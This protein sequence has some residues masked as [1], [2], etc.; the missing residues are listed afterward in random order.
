M[1]LKYLFAF[2][3]A[4]AS[5]GGSATA[6]EL[7]GRWISAAPENIGQMHAIRD[8][9]FDDGRWSVDFVGFADAEATAPLFTATVSGTYVIGGDAQVDEAWSAVFHIAARSV[10]ANSPAGVSMFE[11]LGCRLDEGVAMDLTVDGCGFLPSVMA[12]AVEYDL[13]AIHDDQLFLGDRSG[14]LSLERP[15]K[16]IRYP[17]VRAGE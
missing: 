13:I 2:S 7:D 6:Q 11:S 12:S 16:L 4:V 15:G 9:T 14:D 1:K 3:I 17:L 10:T 5:L 8:F